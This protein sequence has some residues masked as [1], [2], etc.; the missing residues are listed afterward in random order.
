MS[1]SDDEEEYVVYGRPLQVEQES[2]KGQYAKDVQDKSITKALPVWQQVMAFPKQ[3]GR[4]VILYSSSIR[5]R[6]YQ[7]GV[8][9]PRGF[10]CSL[11]CCPQTLAG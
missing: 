8:P 9:S 1:A 5:P 4:L 6:Y 3:F 10:A 2:A 7:N 11:E